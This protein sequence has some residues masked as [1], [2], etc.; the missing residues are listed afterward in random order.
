MI[1]IDEKWL[2]KKQLKMLEDE[3]KETEA[4]NE[5]QWKKYLDMLGPAEVARREK[6]YTENMVKI[7]E[8]AMKK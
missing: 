4:F 3:E 5:A 2:T 1:Y 6:E 8:D 7:I